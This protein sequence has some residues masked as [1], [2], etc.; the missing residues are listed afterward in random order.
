MPAAIRLFPVAFP[1]FVKVLLAM[2]VTKPHSACRVGSKKE[3]AS[4][5]EPKYRM[6][7]I[8]IDPPRVGER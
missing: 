1:D 6:K 3:T 7:S 8:P 2:Q 5:L 4:M